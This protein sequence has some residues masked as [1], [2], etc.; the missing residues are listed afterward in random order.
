MQS[1]Q[2]RRLCASIMHKLQIEHGLHERADLIAGYA[3]Y[4]VGRQVVSQRCVPANPPTFTSA[5]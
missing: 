3:V 1:R 5:L 2:I 4:A